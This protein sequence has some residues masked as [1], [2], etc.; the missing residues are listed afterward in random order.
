M[1]VGCGTGEADQ[2]GGH[3]SN[4]GRGGDDGVTNCNA[5]TFIPLIHY[6][7][8]LVEQNSEAKDLNSGWLQI[9]V[10]TG[11]SPSACVA[12]LPGGLHE[13]RL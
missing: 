11:K 8:S 5:L 9:L 6:N 13:F 3:C 10:F 12:G 1:D 7:S 4:A 2:L